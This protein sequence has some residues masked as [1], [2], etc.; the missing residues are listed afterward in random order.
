[1]DYIDMLKEE[2]LERKIRRPHYSERAFA[3]DLKLSSSFISLLFNRKRSL[4]PKTSIEIIKNIGWNDEKIEQFI[5][6]LKSDQFATSSLSTLDK[7]YVQRDLDLDEFK[8]ISNVKHFAILEFIQSKTGCTPAKIIACI[9]IEKTE[10]ELI[11]N[12]LLRL[13]MISKE[14]A[15]FYAEDVNR[16]VHGV[17]SEAIRNY[18]RQ[19]INLALES[20]DEQDFNQRELRSLTLSID[21]QKM[22]LA[23]KSIDEF[24][25][26]FNK[27]FGNKKNGEI[28]QLNTQLFS[29][30][31]KKDE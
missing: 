19:S 27:K 12:R 29:H 8:L 16:K 14:G 6:A 5:N 20:I 13:N 23:K 2:Y 31:R 25:T 24:I 9:K 11:L 4:S 26:G 15:H 30:Q 3:R 21:P 1:M 28:Y 10:C 18:H 22:K 17:P 7:D